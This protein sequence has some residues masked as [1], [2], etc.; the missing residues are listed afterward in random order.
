[1]A[2]SYDPADALADFAR[3]QSITFPLLADPGSQTIEAYGVRDPSGD[4]IPHPCTFLVG[5]DGVVRAKLAEE[6]YRTRHTTDA[7]IEAARRLP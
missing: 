3:K 7:L 5:A 1:M 2:V 4:G 6:G